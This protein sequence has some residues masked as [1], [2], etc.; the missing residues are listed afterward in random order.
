MNNGACYAFGLNYTCI[1]PQ[2]Y[3]GLRCEITPP[4]ICI[5]PCANNGT[6]AIRPTDNVQI[7]V[8]LSGYTGSRCEIQ[9]SPCIPVPCLNNGICVPSTYANGS[10][11]FICVCTPPYTGKS[12]LF[13][14]G[15]NERKNSFLGPLCAN[16]I[17]LT[18]GNITCL[19]G[20]ICL[21]VGNRSICQCPSLF[22]GT[23]CEFLI[24]ACDSKFIGK[25]KLIVLHVSG[26]PCV[27]D[28]TCQTILV[29]RKKRQ[30]PVVTSTNTGYFCQCP[31]FY[32]GVRCETYVT[33]CASN[34]CQN[35]GTC[36]QDGISNNIRCVCPPNFTGI[37]CNI[38]FNGSNICTA[39]PA[40]CFNGGTCRAN[41]SLS[42][43]FS[44]DCT[45]LTTG[46]YCEQPLNQCQRNPSICPNNGT[47]VSALSMDF[48]PV[49]HRLIFCL[50]RSQL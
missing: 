34:P 9:I 33:L 47:C 12:V 23:R 24:N 8:C 15:R 48:S 13:H 35:N 17:P 31:P 4:A 27:N 37:L 22:T 6:C 49:F 46:Q 28:G 32:T 18:C 7:C 44:C 40:I 5:L 3:S 21:L 45:P 16:Y 26:Q 20:G 36:Y 39:N 2:G 25:E 19:N 42:Q 43:G 29:G 11:G 14:I 50:F 1:C 30:Q 41:G 10:F 38:P